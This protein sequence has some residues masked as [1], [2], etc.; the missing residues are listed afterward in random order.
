MR[1]P[2]LI[3]LMALI[4]AA[5]V[6][7][8]GKHNYRS[9]PRSEGNCPKVYIGFG[10]GINFSTGLL[11]INVDVPVVGGLSL[12]S[13]AGLS[14]W[15]YKVY[16]EAR[17]AFKP[18]NRGWAIGTGLTLN[19]GLS[20]FSSTMPTTYG[21][22]TVTM[23]LQPKTNVFLC[24]YHFWTM[25]KRYNRFYLQFGYSVPLSNYDYVITSGDV[26][27]SEGAAAMD[28]LSPGGLIFG[29][30]FSFGLGG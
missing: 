29:I 30:G 23:D 22:R 6:S 11:G 16:G 17:Y 27:T 18:C 12:S 19:T 14:T 9:K 26:L 7:A 21:E 1:K 20:D 10:T 15:G 3:A 2:L 8:Q 28:I 13:G 5:A 25:G 24:G 4:S